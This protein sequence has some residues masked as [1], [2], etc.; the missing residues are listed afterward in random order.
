MADNDEQA[1][2]RM[3]YAQEL[4]AYTYQQLV[5]ARDAAE[6]NK[7]KTSEGA[8]AESTGTQ[9]ASTRKVLTKSEQV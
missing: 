4:V 5:A 2:E 6:E 8:A 3:S 1:K 9:A 7:D